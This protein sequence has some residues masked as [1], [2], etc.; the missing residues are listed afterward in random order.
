M[1]ET[2]GL[3]GSSRSSGHLCVIVSVHP[4]KLQPL[5]PS[6]G[7]RDSRRCD[8]LGHP[9][10]KA[11]SSI[12]TPGWNHLYGNTSK[13][14]SMVSISKLCFN[15]Q[16]FL[17]EQKAALLFPGQTAPRARQQLLET[18]LFLNH[19]A[20]EK[21]WAKGR[22]ANSLEVSILISRAQYKNLFII[23]FSFKID[24]HF[25]HWSSDLTI[26][27]H[28]KKKSYLEVNDI[29]EGTKSKGRS[30]LPPD[31]PYLEKN[32]GCDHFTDTA[33]GSWF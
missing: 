6:A 22:Q 2:L 13:G 14:D 17:W 12:L 18:L 23:T 9:K 21:S 1:V 5:S 4:K 10:L 28:L 8:F 20:G 24:Y 30:P 16:L 31:S 19:P 32:L 33:F 7:D 15:Q 27:H 11:I 26:S 25:W 3:L 29:K